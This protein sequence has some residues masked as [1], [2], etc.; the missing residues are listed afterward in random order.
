MTS[1]HDF[2]NDA[3]FGKNLQSMNKPKP[4]DPTEQ[5]RRV[6]YLTTLATLDGRD[7]PSHPRHGVFTGLF[8]QRLRQ[9]VEEDKAR[10]LDQPAS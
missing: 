7:D 9:L 8:Q 2:D 1:V 10:L 3:I 4:L 5:N 6:E